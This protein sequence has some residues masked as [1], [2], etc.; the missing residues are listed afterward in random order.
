MVLGT[1]SPCWQSKY[2]VPTRNSI[3]DDVMQDTIAVQIGFWV[4]GIHSV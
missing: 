3:I 1:E 4:I 2:S